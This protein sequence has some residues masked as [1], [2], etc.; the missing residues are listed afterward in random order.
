MLYAKQRL[1]NFMPVES[2]RM[3]CRVPPLAVEEIHV[4]LVIEA[5]D[6]EPVTQKCDRD[7]N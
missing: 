3:S 7:L 4:R 6:I 5:F 1:S 2:R